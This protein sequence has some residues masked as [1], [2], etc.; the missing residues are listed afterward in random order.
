MT[1]VQ[2][3]R[4][5]S[6][7]VLSVASAPRRALAT[8]LR[9]RAVRLRV[10]CSEACRVTGDARR[11]SRRVARLRGSRASAGTVTLTL[12]LSRADRRRLRRARR[13]TL[14]LRL[15]AVD[16][17]GNRRLQTATLRLRR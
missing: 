3:S 1:V 7:P 15:T 17:A 13:L 4:D 11:G 10:R 16:A 8:L 5:L 2:E 6:A 9:G 14:R 12:R